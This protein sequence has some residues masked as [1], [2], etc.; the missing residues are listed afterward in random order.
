[1]NCHKK[2][3]TLFGFGVKLEEVGRMGWRDVMAYPGVPKRSVL[4]HGDN[5]PDQGA[6]RQSRV[7]NNSLQSFRRS[8]QLKHSILP[9]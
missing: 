5:S 2:I 4:I 1:M 8:C 9:L 3:D 6:T 7:R